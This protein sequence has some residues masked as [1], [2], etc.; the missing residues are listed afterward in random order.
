MLSWENDTK[1]K[2]IITKVINYNK[3]VRKQCWLGNDA[4]I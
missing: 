3:M 1:L 4:D 2:K